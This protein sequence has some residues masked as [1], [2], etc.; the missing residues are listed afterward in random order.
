MSRKYRRPSIYTIIAIIIIAGIFLIPFCRSTFLDGG[1]TMYSPLVPWY[2]FVV[3][4]QA[5]F[6]P[7]D[8]HS[9]DDV[10]T[11]DGE[12][13]QIDEEKTDNEEPEVEYPKYIGGHGLWFFG[14]VEIVFD[15]YEVYADGHT[16]RVSGF[17]INVGGSV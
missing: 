3:Y 17:A 4:H 12:P 9:S 2:G 6:R 13:F 10:R 15:K 14:A 1:S 16:E 7:H 5:T 8:Q 11:P